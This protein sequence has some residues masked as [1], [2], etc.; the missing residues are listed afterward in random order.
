MHTFT[1]LVDHCASFTLDALNQAEEKSIA[2]LQNSASTS[3]VKSLQ[4]VQLQKAISAVGM[5]SM[6]ES[7]LQDG[8]NCKDGFNE[9]KKILAYAGETD[10][11]D[12]FN[13]WYLAINVLKHG[14]GHSFDRLLAKVAELPFRI[15]HPGEEFFREGDISEVSTL[16]QVD[17]AFVQNCASLIR[18]V[19]V[20]INRICPKF[21]G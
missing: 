19:S 18:E 7:M 17:N 3:L 21:I 11:K 4:M 16:I 15:K 20:T 14:R 13:D 9:A 12:R 6:F 2:D 10:L 8:L 5:F 1:E